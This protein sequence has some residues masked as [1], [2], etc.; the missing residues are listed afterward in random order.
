[1]TVPVESYIPRI[2]EVLSSTGGS[3]CLSKMDLT[4][5]FFQMRIAEKDRHK[6]AFTTH[7]GTYEYVVSA[8]G[9]RNVPAIFNFAVSK[10]F[11]EQRRIVSTFFDDFIGHSKG[12]S[13]DEAVRQHLGDIRV[14]F[15]KCRENNLVLNLSKS[16][17]FQQ[18]ISA[19]GFRLSENKLL[20]PLSMSGSLEKLETPRSVKEVQAFLGWA[21]YY[22]RFIK[23][24]SIIAAP[25]SAL[26]GA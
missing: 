6:T 19:L 18:E 4:S 13:W 3:K 10:C 7:L 16:E 14:I 23:E 24:F 5:G 26:G 20:L 25:L 12:N 1:M 8:L 11:I 2:D 15:E 21:V 22:R 9:M 17:F